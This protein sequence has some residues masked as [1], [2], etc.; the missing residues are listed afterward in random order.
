MKHRVSHRQTDGFTLVELLV[1]IAIIGVLV[2]LLLPAIQA[3]RES[4]RRS[5][6]TNNL[7]QIGLA[8]HNYYSAQN[9]FAPGFLGPMEGDPGNLDDKTVQWLGLYTFLLPYFEQAGVANQMNDIDLGIDQKDTPYWT[10]AEH[11]NTWAASQWQLNMLRCPTVPDEK[12]YY[13][14]WDKIAFR[15]THHQLLVEGWPAKDIQMGETNYLGV[16]GWR[17]PVSANF[18]SAE[19]YNSMLGVFYN[20]SKTGTQNISDGTSNTLMFG[21]AA[22]TIG[23]NI[24]V[25]GATYNGKMDSHSWTGTNTLPVMYGLDSSRDNSGGTVFDAHWAYFTSLHTSVV[26]F[27]FADGSVRQLDKSIG[28][29]PLKMLAAMADGGVVNEGYN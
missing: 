17:G 7:K 12:P 11:P 21:E 14:Y 19:T 10:Q 8:A 5:Q 15:S 29:E 26:Q 4:A 25:G 9:R 20:R 6:C 16:S 2:A 27:C 3:A 1:V 22:G 24:N 13:A 18:P 23:N 28:E